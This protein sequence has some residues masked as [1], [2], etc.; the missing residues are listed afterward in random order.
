LFNHLP[1]DV[2]KE[3]EVE[4]IEE[5]KIGCLVNGEYFEQSLDFIN[6]RNAKHKHERMYPFMLILYGCFWIDNDEKISLQICSIL[7]QNISDEDL[8]S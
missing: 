3:F 4:L 1:P 8:Y 6:K 7:R 5:F 2:K